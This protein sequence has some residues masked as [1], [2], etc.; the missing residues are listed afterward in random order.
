LVLFSG[1]PQEFLSQK[2][3]K[4]SYCAQSDE[5]IKITGF[6]EAQFYITAKG[7]YIISQTNRSCIVKVI[8]DNIKHLNMNGALLLWIITAAVLL[9]K[10]LGV[11]KFV[12]ATY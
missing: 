8:S 4:L 12:F 2:G 9:T 10:S 11:F 1:Q 7:F 5:N 6:K 3:H